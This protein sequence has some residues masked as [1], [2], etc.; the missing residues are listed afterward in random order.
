MDDGTV[1]DNPNI[2]AGDT[3]RLY[4]IR[5]DDQM[6]L[7][8]EG[9]IVFRGEIEPRSAGIAGGSGVFVFSDLCHNGYHIRRPGRF[10]LGG[11]RK[12]HFQRDLV[13]HLPICHVA[14]AGGLSA[15]ALV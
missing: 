11:D 12:G 9:Q 15:S 14:H 3:I 8:A 6:R 13:F 1:I 10:V 5:K 2:H 4:H 7:I